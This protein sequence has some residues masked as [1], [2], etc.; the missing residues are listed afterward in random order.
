[1][2]LVIFDYGILS[3]RSVRKVYAMDKAWKHLV[4]FG[5]WSVLFAS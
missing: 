2:K 5:V 4:E 1:M 3:V